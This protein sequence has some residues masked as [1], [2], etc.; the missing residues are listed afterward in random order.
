MIALCAQPGYKILQLFKNPWATIQ[1]W[2][3]SALNH[4]LFIHR[5]ST[6]GKSRMKSFVKPA[7]HACLLTLLGLSTPAL[8]DLA[9]D[10]EKLLNWAET[11]YPQY[12]P[13]H[14]TTKTAGEWIYR[15]YSELGIYAGV[16]KNDNNVYVLGGPWNN[17]TVVGSLAALMTIVNATPTG[18]WSTAA[19]FSAVGAG[20]P[21]IAMDNAGNA[22]ALWVQDVAGVST[23]DLMTSRFVAGSGWSAP[24]PLEND[25]DGTVQSTEFHLTMDQTSGR[26]VATWHQFTSAAKFDLWA[27]IYDPATGWGLAAR[28]EDATDTLGFSRAG[29]D[30][31]GNAIAVWSQASTGGRFSVYANRYAV[32]SGWGTRQLLETNEFVGGSDGDARI[33]VTPTGNA[34][35]VWKAAPGIS[36]SGT[37]IWTNRYTV[38]SGWSTATELVSDNSTALQLGNANG[39][40]EIVAYGNGDAL[41]AWAQ[42]NFVNSAYQYT[43]QTKR[44]TAGAWQ[45]DSTPVAPMVATTKGL[46]STFNI[47]TNPS[48]ATVVSW[49]LED[50]SVQAS[51]APAVGAFAAPIALKTPGPLEVLSVP[52]VGI[53]NAGNALVAWQQKGTGNANNVVAARYTAGG[54]WAAGE[55]LAP[56]ITQATPAVAVAGNGN[57]LLTWHTFTNTG[58]VAYSRYY[59]KAP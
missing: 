7:A 39:G 47:A 27:R 57:A 23:D 49:A 41:L 22:I 44:Y 58:T 29:I 43:V 53:D 21:N 15:E 9:S 3:G 32:G 5:T 12:F 55:V 52:D 50:Y 2:E 30:A 59:Q 20:A 54:S 51:V 45:A 1:A 46:S 31:S 38:G 36:G 26:A 16:N 17:P 14:K 33:A 8:A 24:T 48:G 28:V 37:D 4:V 18:G 42:L 25:N 13:S 34:I 6:K 40:L 35:V 19:A 11:T 10:T 56:G